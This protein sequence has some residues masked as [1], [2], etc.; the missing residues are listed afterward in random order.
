MRFSSHSPVGLAI[1]ALDRPMIR[2]YRD[3]LPG[4]IA[5]AQCRMS[6]YIHTTRRTNMLSISPIFNRLV[7]GPTPAREMRHCCRMHHDPQ[8]KQ[9]S[10]LRLGYRAYPLIPWSK[11]D[12]GGRS[13][14]KE[15]RSPLRLLLESHWFHWLTWVGKIIYATAVANLV[16]VKLELGGTGLGS[17]AKAIVDYQ[18]Y[19]WSTNLVTFIFCHPSRFH[20]RLFVLQCW[21]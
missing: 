4:P 13:G 17:I 2:A 21:N 5:H 1:P 8:A 14:A 18:P 10:E 3:W 16:T 20:K 11:C 7:S 6:V 19:I 9:S 15:N 12:C